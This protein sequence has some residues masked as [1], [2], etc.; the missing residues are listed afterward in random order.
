MN[1]WLLPT[2]IVGFL[3]LLSAWFRSPAN[4]PDVTAVILNWVRLSNVVQIVSTLCPEPT[5]AQIVVWNNNPRP[6]VL[7]DFADSR[8]SKLKLLNSP[9]NRYFEARFLAC[10][11]ASTPYCFIQDDDYLVAPAIVRSLR[12]RVTSND[13]FLAPPDEWLASRTLSVESEKI[14]FGFAWLGYGSMVLQSNVRQFLALLDQLGLSTD[15]KKMA[16]NYYSIF[17]NQYPEVW[18]AQPRPLFSGGAFT[19]GTEGIERNRRHIAAAAA[20]LDANMG[21]AGLPY[22]SKSSASRE[23]WERAPCWHETCLLETTVQLLPDV[24]SRQIHAEAKDVFAHEALLASSLAT[25]FVANNDGSP[26]FHAVDGDP[27]T[28]FRSYFNATEGDT[29]VLDM[30]SAFHHENAYWTWVVDEATQKTLQSCQFSYSLDKI[31][32]KEMEEPVQ[33]LR[34]CRVKL[35]HPARYLKARLGRSQASGLAS[36]LHVAYIQN[37]GKSTDDLMY[38]LTAHL[39]LNAIYWGLTALSIMGKPDALDKDDVIKF[40]LSCWDDEAAGFGAHPGHDAHIHAT[41]SAIQILVIY[42]SL[43][44]LDVPRVT[45]FILSLQQPSGV[46]AGDSFGEVDTRFSYIAVNALSLLGQLDQLDKDKTVE[47]IKKCRNFDGG[48]GNSIGAESH[49]GQVFVCTATLAILDRLD[50]IDTEMMSWWLAERQLPNGGLNGRPEKLPDVCYSFW[51]LS[52]LSILNKVSWIDCDKLTEFILSAQDLE[53]GGIADRPDNVADVFHTQF[54]I[55]GLSILGYP[56]LVDL[57]PV[58]CMPAPIIERMGLRKGWK[59]LDR[60]TA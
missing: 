8:C 11:N 50:V 37:L 6:L 25:E 28:A 41:L 27:A 35:S 7:E 45:K 44:V 16:D 9:K 1:R 12:A 31:S 46:F 60:R 4:A 14:H 39:R 21:K 52:A 34:E 30:T 18:I 59:S 33:C 57:D 23:K 10:A 53:K 15:E 56:G 36:D 54:G 47:Y 24:S 13:I 55:A 20:Y 32:W 26:L 42:D 38:H 51:V 48:F 2:F 3:G 17:R 49:S 22:I 58:Y 43:H 5:L 29:F 40:V 19:V